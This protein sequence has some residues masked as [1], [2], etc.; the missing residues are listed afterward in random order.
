MVQC[1][2]MPRRQYSHLPQDEMQEISTGSPGRKS[3]HARP[4]RI[5]HPDALMPED[6]PRRAGRDVALEDVQ[7]GAANRGFGDPH[8]RVA[9]RLDFRLG[10]VFQG[11]Q[12]RPAVNKCFHRFPWVGRHAIRRTPR[13]RMP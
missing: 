5:D 2:Y 8:H 6:A 4:H 3:G 7:V 13:W 12:A 11:L 1:E 9:G 10:A